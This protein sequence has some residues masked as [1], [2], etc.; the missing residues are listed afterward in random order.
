MPYNRNTGVASLM[1]RPVQGYGCGGVVRKYAAGGYVP[2]TRTYRAPPVGYRPGVDPELEY[3]D[4]ADVPVDPVTGVGAPLQAYAPNIMDSDRGGDLR[5]KPGD[6]ANEALGRDRPVTDPRGQTFGQMVQDFVVNN[7]GTIAGV[8]SGV[9]LGGVV[10]SKFDPA[11]R[12]YGDPEINLPKTVDEMLGHFADVKDSSLAP[13]ARR[14]G[15]SESSAAST[16]GP[17]RYKR[18]RDDRD[19]S[20]PS[21]SGG[22]S[23][24]SGSGAPTGYGGGPGKRFAEGGIVAPQDKQN[25]IV[26]GAVAAVLGQHP[27]P[28]KAVNAFVQVYGQEKFEVLRQQVIASQSAGPR[29]QAGVGSLIAGQPGDG[30]SDSIPATIDGREPAELSSGEV[31][32]PADV[33][34]GLGNGSSDAGAKVLES[35]N[36]D[37]RKLRT[38][39]R[40]Q[41]GAIDPQQIIPRAG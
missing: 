3:F 18:D 22:Y 34:S 25:P 15:W 35:M 28:E 17:A 26:E 16:G 37:V 24:R 33:V 27:E 39:Q 13:G 14:G 12:N 9:P 29:S 20:G 10:G 5:R 7:A 6:I 41:P 21:S 23:S 2:Q 31:V 32:V 11:P 19:E 8:L 38:G 4:Y 1:T 36:E 30:L 40:N